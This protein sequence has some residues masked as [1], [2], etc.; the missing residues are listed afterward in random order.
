MMT[1]GKK[2]LKKKEVL[3]SFTQRGRDEDTNTH[4]H[5]SQKYGFISG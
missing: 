1:R 4:S 2:R 3:S 5:A